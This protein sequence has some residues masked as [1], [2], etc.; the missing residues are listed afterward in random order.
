MTKISWDSS[1]HHG[2]LGSQHVAGKMSNHSSQA[3]L[4]M[5]FEE[6]KKLKQDL[7]GGRNN[8]EVHCAVK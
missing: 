6:K 5:S 8:T 3:A 2:M 7:E 1:N 4:Q